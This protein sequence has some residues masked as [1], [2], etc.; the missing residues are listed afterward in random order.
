MKRV[1]I[2]MSGGVD[3][4]VCAALLKEQG[5]EVIGLFMR[6]WIEI[7][8]SCPA[9]ADYEDVARVCERLDIPYYT[10]DFSKEYWQQVFSSFLQ[11]Y[12]S[13]LT[14]NPDILCN[15][16][17]KFKAFFN[18]ALTLGA[19]YVATGHYCRTAGPEQ[20]YALMKGLDPLKDQS[21]FL[22][23]IDGTV[24]S[25]VL[26]PI[27]DLPKTQV[28]E[29]AKK[30][31]LA[32]S[33]KK[34]ST[35]ICF[36]GERPFEEFLGQY[37][38]GSKGEFRTLD[39]TKVGQHNGAQFYTIGQRKGLGLG[40]AGDAWFVLGKDQKNNVVYV[41]RG[42]EHPALFSQRLLANE[43]HWITT[44]PQGPGPWKLMAKVRYRQSDQ[45]CQVFIR[46]DGQLQ[47]DFD[48]P[49]RAITPGQYVVFYQGEVCLG[50]ATIRGIE[51]NLWVQTNNR[52][53]PFPTIF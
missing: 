33:E 48:S 15:R 5:Y 32:T 36:I 22:H 8:G 46:P 20:N 13:G 24:L 11:D 50:G 21:Y 34:D 12:K 10:V 26:F 28:R 42:Q 6:N 40:G 43:V 4:S 53:L 7:D 1:V 35:G 9:E 38:K 41:E 37:L 52:S 16:E 2:G 25:K 49:Q 47:V 19:D 3:S 31:K 14:P 27:G 17:I 45:A 29:L 44:P 51:N 23:A 18:Y 30:Y 39:N